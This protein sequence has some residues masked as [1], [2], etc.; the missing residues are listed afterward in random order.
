MKSK[1]RFNFWP[2]TLNS[3]KKIEQA[4]PQVLQGIAITHEH[5][6]V[7]QELP[8]ITK[9]SDSLDSDSSKSII[10]NHAALPVEFQRYDKDKVSELLKVIRNKVTIS[11]QFRLFIS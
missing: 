1:T 7:L 6:M 8:V 4:H 10:K 11:S 9:L 2:I 3:L 5:Q